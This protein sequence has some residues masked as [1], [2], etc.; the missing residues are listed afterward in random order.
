MA[1]VWVSVGQ[2]S[3]AREEREGGWVAAWATVACVVWSCNGHDLKL[4]A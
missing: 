4:E 3:K 1:P 2:E